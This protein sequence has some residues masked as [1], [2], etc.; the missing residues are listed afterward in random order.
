MIRNEYADL[1]GRVGNDPYSCYVVWVRL[2]HRIICDGAVCYKR[3]LDIRRDGFRA[4]YA[5]NPRF[6]RRAVLAE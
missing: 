1:V 6:H 4:A 2:P 5:S 3:A